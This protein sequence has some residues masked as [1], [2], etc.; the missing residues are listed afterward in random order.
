[1]A[2]GLRKH[3]VKHCTITQ[4]Q[5]PIIGAAYRQAVYDLWAHVF[6]LHAV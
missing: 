6:R 4:V 2:G 1:M 5:V 3:G